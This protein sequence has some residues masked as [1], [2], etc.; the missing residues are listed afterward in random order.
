MIANGNIQK[1][2]ERR[3]KKE[4]TK[5]KHSPTQVKSRL[6]FMSRFSFTP[7]IVIAP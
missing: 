3:I 4:G 6:F 7:S 1:K 2:I 5:K